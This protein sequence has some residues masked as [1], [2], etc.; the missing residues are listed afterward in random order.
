MELMLNPICGLCVTKLIVHLNECH[1]K[2][3]EITL[4][5]FNNIGNFNEWKRK[6]VFQNHFMCSTTPVAC[7]VLTGKPTCIVIG[8]VFFVIQRGTRFL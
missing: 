7:K 6:K 4:H 1:E 8:L 2:V 3:I 5:H